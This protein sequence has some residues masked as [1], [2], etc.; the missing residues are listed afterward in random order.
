MPA[1]SVSEKLLIGP[2]STLWSSQPSR[3]DLIAPLPEGVER[4]VA[5][6]DATTALM[7]A[8]DSDSL[9]KVLYARRK[10]LAAPS[11]FW[12]VYPKA[13]RTDINRDT[14]WPILAEYGMRPI[15]QVAIDEVWSALRFRPRRDGEM[16][17]APGR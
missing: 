6:G 15:S 3:V 4:V 14:L 16:P 2:G 5:L 1:K 17:F 7:F 11:A 8:D 13:N 9:R 12:I 10:E